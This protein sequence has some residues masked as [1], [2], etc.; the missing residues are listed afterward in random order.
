[1]AIHKITPRYLNFEDD[2]RLVKR[3][4]MTDAVNVRI[5][6]DDDGDAGVVKNVAGNTQVSFVDATAD[7]L[8]SGDNKVIGSVRN[9]VK[10]ELMFFV[11]NSNGNHRIY[12]Y[13]DSIERVVTVYKNEVTGTVGSASADTLGFKA[14]D[15]VDAAVLVDKDGDTLLYFTNGRGEP[16]KINVDKAIRG[17]YPDGYEAVEAYISLIKKPPL[18][19]PTFVFN[20]DPEIKTNRFLGRQ[21]QFACQYVY[22]DGEV[23]AISPITE[24]TKSTEHQDLGITSNEALQSIHN[25]VVITCKR[26]NSDIRKIRFLA[27]E[28]NTGVFFIIKDVDTQFSSDP[29]STVSIEFSNEKAY[30]PISNDENNKQFDAVGE[31]VKSI[32]I[33]GN[34]IFLGNYK[35]GFDLNDEGSISLNPNYHLL[36]DPIEVTHPDDVSDGDAS[37]NAFTNGMYT[38]HFGYLGNANNPYPNFGG[39][40][41]MFTKLDLDAAGIDADSDFNSYKSF[42]LSVVFSNI[43]AQ[44]FAL[45]QLGGGDQIDQSGF[46]SNVSPLRFSIVTSLTGRYSSRTEIRDAII[47]DINGLSPFRLSITSASNKVVDGAGYSGEIDVKV[48]ALS[49]IPTFRPEF[50]SGDNCITLFLEPQHINVKR[51]GKNT[52]NFPVIRPKLNDYTLIDL[53][54]NG[55]K[56]NF[57]NATR[58]CIFLGVNCNAVGLLNESDTAMSFKAGANHAFGIVY[59]DKN[60]RLSTVRPI[61]EKNVE[62]FDSSVRDGNAGRT[63][64]VVRIPSTDTPPENAVRW[65]PV[66]AGNTDVGNFIQYTVNDAFKASKTDDDGV[67]TGVN[68]ENK[69]Y[70]SARGFQGKEN[71]YIET[72][73]PE[74]SYTHAKG[75][76][77]KIV[78][79]DNDDGEPQRNTDKEF[80]VLGYKDL[81]EGDSPILTSTTNTYDVFERTGSFFVIQKKTNETEFTDSSTNTDTKF[82]KKCLVEIRS[83]KFST[84]NQV[85]YQMGKSYDIQNGVHKGEDRKQYLTYTS[86][87]G[88]NGSYTL[89][90]LSRVYVGDTLVISG[91]SPNEF[92]VYSVSKKGDTYEVKVS[93]QYQ[94]S[95]DIT[96]PTYT[97]NFTTGV[98][99]FTVFESN[100]SASRVASVTDDF[101]TVVNN[102]LQLNC[103]D[104]VSAKHILRKQ[105]PISFATGDLSGRNLLCSFKMLVDGANTG[106]VSA[107]LSDGRTTSLGVV[108]AGKVVEK[109]RWQT[110]TDIPFTQDSS[111]S[112]LIFMGLDSSD[113][114]TFAAGTND[115]FYIADVV[116]QEADISVSG[117]DNDAVIELDNGDVYF[118]KRI[119]NYGH[120]NSTTNTSSVYIDYIEDYRFTDFISTVSNDFGKPNAFS[121]EAVRVQRLSSLTYSDAYVMD[122]DRLS[123]TSFNNT[124]ANFLDIKNKYG[125]IQRLVDIEDAFY[126][127]QEHKVTLFPVN[128]NVLQSAAGDATVTLSTDVVNVNSSK[129]FAGDYGCGS[130]PETVVYHDGVLYFADRK[131][132]KVFSISS[133]GIKEISDIFADSYIADKLNKADKGG[134]YNIYSG[135]DPNNDEYLLSTRTII[136]KKV[137]VDIGAGADNPLFDIPSNDVS[138]KTDFTPT[139]VNKTSFGSFQIMNFNFEDVDVNF[140]DLGNGVFYVDDAFSDNA[141]EL[142]TAIDSLS[143]GTT[144]IV[145]TD[146]NNTFLG[147]AQ[148]DNTNKFVE[149]DPS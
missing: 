7:A 97:S 36:T 89:T 14:T 70:V 99:S 52:V 109:G 67:P 20:S 143:S 140:E 55:G 77:M 113:S 105:D 37:T 34:R 41:S 93:S 90:T 27:R 148:V 62:W 98:D 80:R 92:V 110:F 76:I 78:S 61:G 106:L 24:I 5:D 131:A 66:Y 4:E 96:P 56:Y 74:I 44:Y 35:E 8:P 112:R 114:P 128:R 146:K 95:A 81:V 3:V 11:H 84:E 57:N 100:N 107:C 39:K 83:P 1:M 136:N 69:L 38:G 40:K 43:K 145:Y 73:D 51:S 85:Y 86:L 59:Q 6:A 42:S 130:D 118:R 19:P 60:G 111:Q 22:E 133:S 16:K 47:Q 33:S 122:S 137:Q 126:A 46:L 29:S 147:V 10:G 23:S 94:A 139:S 64:M 144:K 132:N 32:T 65:M 102:I 17:D 13:I 71:S 68:I 79:V 134:E 117:I 31:D 2:E 15:Y 141:M 149:L 91:L 26:T 124:L 121:E 120:L 12:K 30:T 125:A 138:G 53:G 63:S 21:F 87:T 142:D 104:T 103:T 50:L 116:L 82:R 75:D 129:S 101:G 28:G 88:I 54:G 9:N 25:K 108:E 127:V 123:V 72:F 48:H 135:I 119:L 58:S 115:K 45:E 18:E 49:S